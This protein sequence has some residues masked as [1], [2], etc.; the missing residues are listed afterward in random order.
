VYPASASETP[1]QSPPP[2]TKIVAFDGETAEPA[3]PTPPATSPEKIDPRRSAEPV[4]PRTVYYGRVIPTPPNVSVREAAR[5]TPARGRTPVFTSRPAAATAF[6][7]NSPYGIRYDPLT[8]F[9]RMHT[10]V[11]LRANYGDAV[12]AS[13]SG[14]VL[15]AGLRGGYGNCVIV[16]HGNGISTYYAHLSSIAVT[17]G[18]VVEA[19][20]YIGQV[21]S[22]GRS[23][24]PHLH[25]E[26]RANGHPVEPGT[27]IT[28]D[29]GLLYAAGRKVGDPVDPLSTA[30]LPL[31][32]GGTTIAVQW[33]TSGGAKASDQVLA[34]EFE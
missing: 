23:T 34:I 25:Y 24:G 6:S 21:G 3:Q 22:T 31:A 20:E 9:P 30:A 12:G 2:S 4:K 13:M 27:L 1:R 32:P 10:G 8:G 17:T 11:D 19:G 28:I 7:V 18:L 16:D 5:P 15:F 26:V 14:T 29:E 33:D